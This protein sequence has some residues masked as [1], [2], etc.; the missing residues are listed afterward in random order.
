MSI[1]QGEGDNKASKAIEQALH[2][3][4]LQDTSIENASGI[5]INFTCGED[6]TLFE[7]EAALTQL[8]KRAGDQAEIILGVVNDERLDDRVEAILVVTG[9]GGKAIDEAIQE[10]Q[11]NPSRNSLPSNIHN[12]TPVRE[13]PI[14]IPVIPPT[15]QEP[16]YASNT[17][18]LDLPAFLRKPR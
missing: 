11:D 6:L 8:K 9:L 15:N 14:S 4:L 1:G 7:V 5:L 10:I 2:H 16:Y 12:H 17:T 3:P 18:N 13:N